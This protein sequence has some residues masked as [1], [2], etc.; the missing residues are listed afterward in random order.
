MHAWLIIFAVV[1]QYLHCLTG[2][3]IG[4]LTGLLSGLRLKRGLY[5]HEDPETLYLKA[6]AYPGEVLNYCR[7]GTCKNISH[8]GV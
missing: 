3:H 1:Q 6:L 4:Y 8:E 7:I 5:K 2:G